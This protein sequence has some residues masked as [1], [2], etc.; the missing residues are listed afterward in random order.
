M[1]VPGSWNEQ[2][3]DIINYLGLAWYVK[4]TYVPRHW[5]GERVFIRAGSASKSEAQDT[6]RG[7]PP[8]DPPVPR[9][10]TSPVPPA[11]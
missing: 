9:R 5:Q 3:E 4:R 2:Y 1:A 7:V 8:V 6:G 10:K 11:V